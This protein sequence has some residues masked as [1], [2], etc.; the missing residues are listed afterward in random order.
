MKFTVWSEPALPLIVRVSTTRPNK[1]DKVSVPLLTATG[2]FTVKVPVDGLGK[3]PR[4]D[5]DALNG[6]TPLG[7]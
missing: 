4:P 5:V 1:S 6:L 2:I 3:I 7:W